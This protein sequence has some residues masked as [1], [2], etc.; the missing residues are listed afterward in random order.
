MCSLC[1]HKPLSD[2]PSGSTV[3]IERFCDCAGGQCRCRLCALGLTPGT[4]V[5]VDSAGPGGCRIRVRGADL[6]IGQGMAEKVLAS[7][8]QN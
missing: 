1:S 5:I 8:V 4:R 7:P 3:T 6:V 2:F